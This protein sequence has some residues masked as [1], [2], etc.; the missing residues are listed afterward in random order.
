MMEP[1]DLHPA[2]PAPDLPAKDW[3]LTGCEG[4]DPQLI[5]SLLLNEDMLEELNMVLAGVYREIEKNEQR[6]QEFMMDDAEVCI[7]AYGTSARICREAIRRMRK[8]GAKVGLLRPITLWPFPTEAVRKAAE[9]AKA[10]VV[11]EM[12]LGQ[13]IDD[14]KLATECSKP[15]G[16]CGRTGGNVPSTDAIIEEVKKSL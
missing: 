3:A 4:R 1:A 10:L 14:V 12:S 9:K 13:M 2:E 6:S 7:V 8:D 15:V 16:F 11:V 5:R